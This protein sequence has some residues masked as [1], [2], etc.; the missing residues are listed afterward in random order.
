M[1]E[2]HPEKKIY[3]ESNV[4]ELNNLPQ[5]LKWSEEKREE[6][7][8]LSASN[9]KEFNELY[10][11]KLITMK[12]NGKQYSVWRHSLPSG[13]LWI[14]AGNKKVGT[15]YRTEI[16]VD[17][18]DVKLFLDDLYNK[19]SIYHDARLESDKA[20]KMLTDKHGK[21]LF[22]MCN[23]KHCYA[24]RNVPEKGDSRLFVSNSEVIN[25]VPDWWQSFSE[26][27]VNAR[28][29]AISLIKPSLLKGES[30]NDYV[31]VMVYEDS[32]SCIDI[33][34]K[35]EGLFAYI[36]EVKVKSGANLIETYKEI[37]LLCEQ[38]SDLLE[39]EK[40]QFFEG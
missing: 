15:L 35:E 37:T 10:G 38:M 12:E 39:D 2:L 28:E 13:N 3:K 9:L 36:D 30:I 29:T 31:Q 4:K 27:L 8:V 11:K 24:I 19:L 34:L 7:E 5:W 23:R 26:P 14:F 33:I 40:I 21:A 20:F 25:E 17:W 22:E 1:Q 16:N 18:N 6:F 32:T